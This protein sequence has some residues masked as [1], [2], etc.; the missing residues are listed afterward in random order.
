[1]KAKSHVVSKLDLRVFGGS[2]LTSDSY[3]VPKDR[4]E[5]GK[6][7]NEKRKKKERKRKKRNNEK[8]KEK[9]EEKKVK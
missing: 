8:E 3:D 9:K 5:K 4:D 2:A 6:R 1:M 7:N